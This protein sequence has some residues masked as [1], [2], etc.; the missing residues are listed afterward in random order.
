MNEMDSTKDKI[1]DILYTLVAD[2]RLVFWYDDGGQMRDFVNGLEMDGIEILMLK[3]N[4]FTIKHHILTA[5]QPEKGFIVY[6]QKPRPKDRENWLLDLEVQAKQFSADMGS[7]YAA[8]CKIPFELKN[9]VVDNHIEFFKLATNR[10]RLAARVADGMSAGEI[11]R[12]MISIISKTEFSYGQL[13]LALI[14]EALLGKKEICSKLEKYCLDSLF[15]NEIKTAFKYQGNNKIKDLLVVLFKDD[16]DKALGDGKLSNEAHIFMRDWRDSRQHGDTYMAW[17][18]ELEKEMRIKESLQEY[19]LEKLLPIE[20]FPCV[21]KIIAQH[22]QLMVLDGTINV[23][24]MEAIVEER[25][26]KLFF[27]Q[28][29]HTVR[30]LLEARRLFEEID[31]KMADL[32][33]PSPEHGIDLYTSSLYLI[34]SHYRHYFREAKQSES[35]GLLADITEKVQRVYTNLYLQ[36]LGYK[37]QSIVDSMQ[38]WEFKGVTSQQKFYRTY[39]QPYITKGNKLFVII[40]DALRYENAVE[41]EQ[42]VNQLSR[43]S[44]EMKPAMYSTLP[45]YTQLGMAALLPHKELAYEKETDEVFA[46][47]ISSKGTES[48]GKILAKTVA[49]SLAVR[50]EEFLNLNNP[51]AFLKDFDLIY[52]YSNKIDKVGDN[53]DTEG[54]VFKACDDEI[55]HI[56]K[57][58]ELIRNSNGAN[59]LITSDHG[60]LYQ[61]EV[62]DESDFTDFKIMGDILGGSRR[63]VI[64]KNLIEG[65]AVKTWKSEDIGLKKGVQ[66]QIANGINRIRKQGSGSRFVHGGAMLQEI[67]V[68]VIHVNIKKAVDISQV[69]VDILN[70]KSRLTTNSQTI[71]FYQTE[72]V[73]EKIKGIAIKAGFYDMTCNPISDTITLNFNSTSNDTVQREQKHTFLFKNQLSR[74]NGQE[75]YLRMEKQVSDSEQFAYYKEIAYKVSIMFQAEF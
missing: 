33:L 15:W 43:M 42:R 72:A 63:F 21:D 1:R 52:I 14:R 13:A 6:S 29:A 71:S 30:A 46:D 36:K 66:I 55:D 56:V 57:I 35:I 2:H 53:K 5:E 64:G 45:S 11:E 9:Q 68:P 48:R 20:T 70:K 60:Y 67:V 62:L 10:T 12:Q 34:D 26:G 37:W 39:V 16:L 22:L 51:R 47:G 61:N 50:A 65:D 17:A 7:L 8:E 32:N 28:A 54:D 19:P 40:S 59:I 69:N 58:V 3:D 49:R 75:V 25:E 31:L 74:L 27:I 38:A 44:A 73:T 4:E 23:D 24:R 41:L 18:Q